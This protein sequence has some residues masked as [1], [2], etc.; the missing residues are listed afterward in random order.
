M[1]LQMLILYTPPTQ[2]HNF[3]IFKKAHFWLKINFYFCTLDAVGISFLKSGR[4][5]KDILTKLKSTLFDAL[6]HENLT[7]SNVIHPSH[8][9]S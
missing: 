6:Q 8:A 9:Q 1:N 3:P 7:I 4:V 5:A 2:N